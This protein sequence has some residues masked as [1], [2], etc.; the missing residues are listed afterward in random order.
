MKELAQYMVQC[1]KFKSI[2]ESTYKISKPDLC[3]TNDL[4]F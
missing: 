1:H 3:S 4:K 2:A